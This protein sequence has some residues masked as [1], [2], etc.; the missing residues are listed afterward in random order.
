MATEAP[1]S[2][3]APISLY[4]AL[5]PET[6]GDLEIISRA[7]IAWTE[8][9]REA[10]FITDP[11]L[12]IRVELLSGTEGS[13]NLN[14]RIRA[15]RDA[16]SDPKKLKA[17]AL[18][19]AFFFATQ[20]VGWSVGKGF[21]ALWDWGR[22]QLGFN[23][24]ALSDDEKKEIE[25]IVRRIVAARTTNEK[26]MNV[27]RE[28]RKD[29]AVTGVG[30]SLTP[31]R[32]PPYVVPRSEFAERGGLFETDDE[33]IHRRTERDRIVLTL[34]APELSGDEHKWKFIFGAKTLWAH[35]DDQDFKLR[36]APGSNS[37]PR[38][39]TGIRMDVDI[40]TVQEMREGVWTTIEH[41]IIKVHSLSEPITQPAWLSA[42]T[43]DEKPE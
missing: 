8:A 34:V 43:Q 33:I 42:P 3:T 10:A 20:A 25:E 18:G 35:M 1:V 4:V 31:G 15:I 23:V 21:D 14:S 22:T 32:A 13:I 24:E 36:L 12:E 6:R 2:E 9:I 38:M 40:E 39:V 29:E 5:A 30:V 41:R 27:Y 19:I 11:F 28:L 16:V 37:A 26:A 17:I 7:A